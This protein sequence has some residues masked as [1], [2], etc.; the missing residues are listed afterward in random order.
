[1]HVH[2]KAQFYSSFCI[3]LDAGGRKLT[4]IS[5]ISL[6]FAGALP[7]GPSLSF[8]ADID[9]MFDNQCGSGFFHRVAFEV[10]SFHVLFC[11]VPKSK[12]LC[13]RSS[14]DDSFLLFGTI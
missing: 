13:A 12:N 1:M 4:K 11:D 6:A 10:P 2:H 5:H 14:L 8:H 9:W 7:I 3:A